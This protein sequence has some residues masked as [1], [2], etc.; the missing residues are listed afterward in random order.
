[1]KFLVDNQLPPGL[2]RFI[3]TEFDV[4]AVHV[5]DV[6][7]RDASDAEI[8]IYVS[9][10]DSILI[11]K[12]EDFANMILQIPTAK[13]IWVRFGNCRKAFLLNAFER[14]WSRILERLDS[15]DSLIEIR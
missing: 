8:W 4:Q 1:V 7:L 11:S 12:D 2:A 6:G 15:G 13:L 14:M 10:N 5:I 3:Q 9:N